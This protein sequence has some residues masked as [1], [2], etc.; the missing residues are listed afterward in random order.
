MAWEHEGFCYPTGNLKDFFF[1]S[2]R[3]T[4]GRFGGSEEG[5]WSWVQCCAPIVPAARWLRQE[6]HL[7]SGVAA[8]LGNTDPIS[9]KSSEDWEPGAGPS[10][11]EVGS[12]TKAVAGEK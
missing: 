6:D 12:G 9:E 4:P 1:L 3:E 5:D 8:S 2:C 7:N 10:W 11:G